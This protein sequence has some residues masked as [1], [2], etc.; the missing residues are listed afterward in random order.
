MQNASTP[1]TRPWGSQ[2]RIQAFNGLTLPVS[3]LGYSGNKHRYSR[4]SAYNPYLKP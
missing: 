1:Y 4:P 2:L 3:G